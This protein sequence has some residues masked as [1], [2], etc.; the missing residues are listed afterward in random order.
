MIDKH[1]GFTKTEL[2]EISNTAPPHTNSLPENISDYLQRFNHNNVNDLRAE[3]STAHS[4]EQAEYDQKLHHDLDWI[5]HTMHSYIRLMESGALK[6][7]H[8]EQ[9][10]NKRVWLPIDNLLD[11]VPNITCKPE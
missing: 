7:M 2:E 6:Y 4:W 8:K 9:W 10:Y 11:D 5:K 1:R 3:L